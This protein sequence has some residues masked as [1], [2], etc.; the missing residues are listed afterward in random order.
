MDK[1]ILQNGYKKLNNLKDTDE[2]DLTGQF[3]EEQIQGADKHMK[4]VQSS[5]ISGK[6][7]LSKKDNVLQKDILA[8]TST[9]HPYEVQAGEQADP[10]RHKAL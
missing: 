6:Y 1:E 7:E 4:P 3:M 5:Q 9:M 10:G 8:A 2:K